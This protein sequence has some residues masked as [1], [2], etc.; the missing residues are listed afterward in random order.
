MAREL[1]AEV[2]HVQ[3]GR[4]LRRTAHRKIE[5]RGRKAAFERRCG[6]R[7]RNPLQRIVAYRDG[8]ALGPA[9][10]APLGDPQHAVA[11]LGAEPSR[12]G[13]LRIVDDPRSLRIGNLHE[14]DIDRRGDLDGRERRQPLAALPLRTCRK[15][16]RPARKREQQASPP[17]TVS[18]AGS[19]GVRAGTPTE[20]PARR[21]VRIS[22]FICFSW[23]EVVIVPA[24]VLKILRN[25]GFIPYFYFRKPTFRRVRAKILNASAGSGKTYQLAYNSSATSSDGPT[26][27]AISSP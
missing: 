15:P 24:K 27:T 21:A 1:H 7:N 6:I 2:L 25:P 14:A 18:A 10:V 20:T 11:Y 16:P 23:S 5:Q 3:I 17:L 13:A 8:R 26:S 9:G 12:I 4:Q 19:P 22:R